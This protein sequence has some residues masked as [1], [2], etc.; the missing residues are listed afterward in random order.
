M[1]FFEEA[2]EVGINLATILWAGG[3]RHL[4]AVVVHLHPAAWADY[5]FGVGHCFHT[6]SGD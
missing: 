5:L 2:A 3:I 4:V 6:R 1:K